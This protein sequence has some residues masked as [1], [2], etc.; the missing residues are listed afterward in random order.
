MARCSVLQRILTLFML[1]VMNLYRLSTA[2]ILSDYT[3]P[4]GKAL[5]LIM[6]EQVGN[7]SSYMN[8]AILDRHQCRIEYSLA[9][10]MLP[11]KAWLCYSMIWLWQPVSLNFDPASLIHLS[12]KSVWAFAL[13]LTRFSVGSIGRWIRFWIKAS[14]SYFDRKRWPQWRWFLSCL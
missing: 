4:M 9:P 13:V 3:N 5:L 2:W 6:Q 8:V 12:L 10:W 11:T 1:K 14:V 7:C